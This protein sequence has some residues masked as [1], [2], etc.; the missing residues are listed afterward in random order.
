[1]VSAPLP[2]YVMFVTNGSMSDQAVTERQLRWSSREP[3]FWQ[4]MGIG[5]GRKS[6]SKRLS[7]FA[8]SDFAFPEKL[9]ELDRR[10]IDNAG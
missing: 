5:K 9:D 8:D 7:D 6:K 4:V 2:V 1:M 10:L 3:I